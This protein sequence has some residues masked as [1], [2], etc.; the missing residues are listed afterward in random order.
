M[1][2]AEESFLEAGHELRSQA[3]GCLPACVHLPR[4][5]KDRRGTFTERLALHSSSASIQYSPLCPLPRV[6]KSAW[7]G[8]TRLRSVESWSNGKVRKARALT[9]I[10]TQIVEMIRYQALTASAIHRSGSDFFASL[11]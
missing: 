3:R 11:P 8:K 10:H 5:G 2:G 9:L 6:L 1:R 4:A 7:S